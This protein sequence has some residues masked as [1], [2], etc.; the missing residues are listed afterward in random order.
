MMAFNYTSIHE[1]AI[2]LIT[3]FGRSITFERIDQTPADTDS[4]WDGPTS[5]SASPDATLTAFAVFVE[6]ITLLSLGLTTRDTDLLK[7]ST[8]IMIVSPPITFTSDDLETYNIAVDGSVRWKIN[9]VHKFK[10]GGT[11]LLYYVGVSR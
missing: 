10:P 4:P 7:Q 9:T 5:A 3:Q 6:P 1:K 11:T 8:Q 2:E